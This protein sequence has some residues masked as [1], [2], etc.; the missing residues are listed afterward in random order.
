MND[1]CLVEAC[2][3]PTR[4]QRLKWAIEQTVGTFVHQSHDRLIRVLGGVPANPKSDYSKLVH[5]FDLAWEDWRDDD[6]QKSIADDVM[7]IVRV[8]GRQGHSGFSAGYMMPLINASLRHEPLTPLT[9]EDDEWVVLDGSSADMSLQNKRNSAVF[10][11]AD[12]TAFYING[13]VFRNPD[14]ATFTSTDSF[15]EVEFPWKKP[16]TI[17]VDVDEDG[18]E[19]N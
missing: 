19:I 17:I 4:F 5:E 9:G 8:F 13:K 18:N 2:D 7:D 1:N 10:K 11:R 6:M 15:V 14:G 16:E 3:E 12:G